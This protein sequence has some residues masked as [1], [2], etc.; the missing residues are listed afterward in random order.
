M[1]VQ[2]V[3][4]LDDNYAYLL[5]DTATMTAAAVDPVE[6]DK[7]LQAAKD[8]GVTVTTILTTHSHWDHAGGN[9][10]MKTKVKDIIVVGGAGDKAEGVTQEVKHGDVVNVGKTEVAVLATPCHT[11]GHVCFFVK[12]EEKKDG[13]P[14]V[15]FTGD[16]M[17]VG[18]CGNLNQGT[19]E[20]MTNNMLN[21]LGSLPAET[22]V[23]VGHEYTL[24]NF[25]FGLYAEPGNKELQAKN[26]WA[27]EQRKNNLPTVPSTIKD[28][29]LTNPFMRVRE[30]SLQAFTG[31][32]TDVEGFYAVRLKKDE[33]GRKQG[34]M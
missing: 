22:L 32:S 31:K 20:Q 24:K 12:G 25:A 19:P 15:V 5:I 21:V 10:A 2:I 7:V 8:T 11:P 16:T 3:P 28:E 34:K 30:K 26:S 1:Q 33:W 17:F 9:N 29:W 13:Q 4:V 27:Q 14:P 6:P 18:G 23:Y